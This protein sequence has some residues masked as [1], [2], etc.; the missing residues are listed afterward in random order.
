[1]NANKGRV[2]LIVSIALIVAGIS[3]MLVSGIRNGEALEQNLYEHG[4]IV[5]AE[6]KTYTITEPFRSVTVSDASADVKICPSDDGTCRVVCGESDTRSYHVRV[7][8]GVLKVLL[9]EDKGTSSFILHYETPP[10]RVYLPEAQYKTLQVETSS[11]SIDVQ[12]GPSWDQAKLKSTSGE[13]RVQDTETG[14]LELS[15]SSGDVYL[16]QLRTN[17]VRI[18]TVSGEVELYACNCGDLSVTSSSGDQ[19]L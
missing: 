2:W 14:D 1:M 17:G 4:A 19:R 18:D 12:S 5:R 10:V 15:S 11:G 8:D 7:E 3:L 9:Q 13:I 6:E 16:F